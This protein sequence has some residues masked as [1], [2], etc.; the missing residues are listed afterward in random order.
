MSELRLPY[1]L[2][3][4]ANETLEETIILNEERRGADHHMVTR[5]PR[6]T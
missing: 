2:L 5:P 4:I 6:T 1:T 3:G